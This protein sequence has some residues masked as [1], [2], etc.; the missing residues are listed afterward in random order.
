MLTV[1]FDITERKR[2]EIFLRTV[3]DTLPVA[4]NIRDAEGRFIL[5]N[6]RLADYFGVEPKDMIGKPFGE[7]NLGPRAIRSCKANFNKFLKQEFPSSTV[8]LNTLGPTAPPNFGSPPASP[9]LTMT[10]GSN[11]C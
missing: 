9:Y 2:A 7:V 11:S 6:R 8:K 3:V 4:L 5:A 10:D 1:S